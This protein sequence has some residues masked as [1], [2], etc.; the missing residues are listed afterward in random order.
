[1]DIMTKIF[2]TLLFFF[3]AAQLIHDWH[4]IPGWGNE[5]IRDIAAIVRVGTF[6]GIFLLGLIAIWVH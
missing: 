5:K 3:A 4:N 2:V 6:A 1:M